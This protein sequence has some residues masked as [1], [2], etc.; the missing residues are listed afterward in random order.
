[1]RALQ[2]GE[3]DAAYTLGFIYEMGHDVPA[4]FQIAVHWYLTCIQVRKR[5]R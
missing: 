4:D 2:W 3:T 1:V 5:D